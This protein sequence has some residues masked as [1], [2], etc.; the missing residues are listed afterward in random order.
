MANSVDPDETVHY[1]PSHQDLHC[2]QSYPSWSAGLKEL[3]HSLTA[4]LILHRNG[5]DV[6]VQGTMFKNN[7]KELNQANGRD[8]SLHYL[9]FVY[10]FH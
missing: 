7:H 1:E 6:K 4:V 3:T 2:L 5:N 10:S 8:V 9:S